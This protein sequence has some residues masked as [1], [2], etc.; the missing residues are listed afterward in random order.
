MNLNEHQRSGKIMDMKAKKIQATPPP[1]NIKEGIINSLATELSFFNYQNYPIPHDPQM[2]RATHYFRS[3]M[4]KRIIGAFVVLKTLQDK[5]ITQKEV[6][7]YF[8]QLK[9]AFV[10]KVFN[11]CV[12]EGWFIA[13]ESHISAKIMC[14]KSDDIMLKSTE[15]YYTEYVSSRDKLKFIS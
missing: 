5:C 14:Y 6:R 9:K 3:H 13:I 11:H 2:R 8:P 7:D 4:N 10:S 12:E 15:Y 1:Y